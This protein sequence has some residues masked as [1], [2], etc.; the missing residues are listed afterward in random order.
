MRTIIMRDK[1]KGLLLGLVI[2]VM[3]SGTVVYASGST[4][5]DV[6]FRDL[7]YMFDGVEKKPVDRGF[8]Y[9]GTTYV[10]LRF[11]SEALGKEVEWD[12]PNETIWIGKIEG[13]F[14]YLSD[15]DYARFDRTKSKDLHI[16]QWD[17]RGVNTLEDHKGGFIIAGN[18]FEHG[19]GFATNG[20]FASGGNASV[21]YNLNGQYSELTAFLG[22][23]DATKNSTH[24]VEFVIIGD[25]KE[26]YRSPK[27]MGGDLPL[28]IEVDLTNVLRLKIEILE[29]DENYRI[30]TYG[31][32]AEAKIFE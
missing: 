3:V 5:I 30:K 6:F 18:K 24:P 19:L 15:I 4:S 23:D 20:R 2:G 7:K 28:P 17:I 31:V 27:I 29:T 25:G 14:K 8:I 16:D 26:I 9:E 22:I 10:P 12:G 21:E 13:R 32:F 1:L 11:V